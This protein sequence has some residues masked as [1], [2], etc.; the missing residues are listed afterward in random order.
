MIISQIVAASE[1]NAI[2]KDNDLMWRL[3]A[4]LKKFK[5]LTTGHCM[6]MGRKN[7]DSIGRLLPGRTSIIITRKHDFKVDGAIVVNSVEEGIKEAKKRNETELFII[8]GGEIYKQTLPLSNKIYF[9]KV[10]AHYPQADTFYPELNMSEWEVVCKESFE[11][12]DK[13]EHNFTFLELKRA[14]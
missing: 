14:T 11:K 5:S 3:S 8:G 12:D 10:N 4:D 9:T 1:D 6:L 2:G 13:N 7:Y